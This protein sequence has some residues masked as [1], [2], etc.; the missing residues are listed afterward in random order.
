[1]EL[2]NCSSSSFLSSSS[3]IETDNNSKNIKQESCWPTFCAVTDNNNLEKEEIIRRK[4]NSLGLLSHKWAKNFIERGFMNGHLPRKLYYD[5]SRP[6]TRH[7]TSKDHVQQTE[8]KTDRKNSGQPAKTQ[9][10]KTVNSSRAR[11]NETKMKL[12]EL[13]T[14][15]GTKQKRQ[16]ST[17]TKTD[18]STRTLTQKGV[19]RKPSLVHCR[20]STHHEENFKTKQSSTVRHWHVKG[21]KWQV[22]N[23]FEVL[24]RLTIES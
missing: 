19:E 9:R 5:I 13:E 16:L 23:N 21:E 14:V 10:S 18:S 1:M 4:A 12:Q 2:V 3:S 24:N 6:A 22:R 20:P 7:N 11:S 17:A 8:A 15:Y